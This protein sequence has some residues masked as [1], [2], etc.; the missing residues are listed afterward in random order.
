MKGKIAFVLGAAVGYVLGSRAGR[1][2][3]EQIKRG[4]EQVWNTAPVQQGVDAVRDATRD[5][6]ENVKQ[7][8]LRAGK[9]AFASL[10]GTQS[11]S[12]S[13]A[14]QHAAE[15]PERPSSTPSPASSGSQTSSTS[16]Q[17]SRA[18]STSSDSAKPGS[19]AA[20]ANS[21]AEAGGGNA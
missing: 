7:S 11:R 9:N 10:V 2:R 8:A 17:S 19:A 15:S 14:S 13:S 4:A 3:Y 16:A 5:T 21:S 18:A 1:E 12:S 20:D 6:V